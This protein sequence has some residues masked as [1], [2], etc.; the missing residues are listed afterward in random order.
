M[1]RCSCI[2]DNLNLLFRRSKPYKITSFLQV[3]VDYLM[4]FEHFPSQW[5]MP[6][7]PRY[8]NFQGYECLKQSFFVILVFWSL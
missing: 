7:C 1:Q 5:D 3:T 8:S 6:P 4:G 2:E